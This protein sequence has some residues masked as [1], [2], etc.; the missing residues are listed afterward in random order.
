MHSPVQRNMPLKRRTGRA[1]S[2][3]DAFP[4]RLHAGTPRKMPAKL[5]GARRVSRG[6]IFSY[7]IGSKAVFMD[8][9]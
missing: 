3:E 1:T 6:K 8:W 5:A 4:T 2:R 7:S 9:K